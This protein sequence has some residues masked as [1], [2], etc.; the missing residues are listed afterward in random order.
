MDLCSD[1]D[2]D[3]LLDA[4]K[5]VKASRISKPQTPAASSTPHNTAS[6]GDAKKRGHAS[7]PTVKKEKKPKLEKPQHDEDEEPELFQDED[8]RWWKRH[9]DLVKIQNLMLKMLD[10][11][12]LEL[13][14]NPLDNLIDLLGG[15]EKVAEM[16]GRARHWV[17]KEDGKLH[18][19]KRTSEDVPQS[20][21]NIVE[22]G[23]FMSDEKHYAIISD[24]AS[25]GISLHADRRHASC[26][27]RRLHFTMELPWSSDKTIQ[28]LG[29]S[30]R[31]NQVTA[32][33][34]SFIFTSCAGET[35]FASSAAARL[36]SLGAILRGDR[37][38]TDAGA[39]LKDFDVDNDYGREALHRMLKECFLEANGGNYQYIPIGPLPG[40]QHPA[41]RVDGAPAD[42]RPFAQGALRVIGFAPKPDQL[43]HLRDGE[44]RSHPVEFTWEFTKT[45]TVSRFLNRLLG[46]KIEHQKI[47]FQH[48]SGLFDQVV[49]D[50]KASGTYD[51]GISEASWDIMANNTKLLESGDLYKCPTSGALAKWA[52]LEIDEGVSWD[53]AMKILQ[54]HRK[55]MRSRLAI[56]EEDLKK[57]ESEIADLDQQNP[58][59]SLGGRRNTVYLQ[60]E[61]R[62]FE[63]NN[64]R[65]SVLKNSGIW[66]RKPSSR[67]H[68]HHGSHRLVVLAIEEPKTVTD[69][70][71]LLIHRP[72][73]W[74]A[75]YMMFGHLTNRYVHVPDYASP[76]EWNN[77]RN[78]WQYYWKALAHEGIQDRLFLDGDH[79]QFQIHPRIC[80]T[81]MVF[82][83][84]LPCLS[85][86]KETLEQLRVKAA[87][88]S[89]NQN[90]VEQINYVMSHDDAKEKNKPL[91]TVVAKQDKKGNRYVGV[92]VDDLSELRDLFNQIM[93][94][95]PQ[96]M[97]VKA[98]GI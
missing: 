28:Q 98:E 24:A 64:L 65:N 42:Y 35:R 44:G 46:L 38:A 60:K 67:E 72:N 23:R 69:K 34:Y 74:R 5:P 73:E 36:Q 21:V 2:D 71:Q 20:K 13:P 68:T 48:F 39:V 59:N 1:S 14:P 57:L 3:D 95:Q 75:C 41:Y 7:A 32:P 79:L 94:G 6:G 15:A 53:S 16:T 97:D 96:D 49:S 17:R 92:E 77:A 40:T 56:A 88:V 84:I 37:N 55:E 54:N 19:V 80:T 78:E 58:N 25:T 70:H 91:I 93:N 89:K 62:K 30:H 29:R 8:G 43:R 61:K 47:L 18:Y 10:D 81:H 87:R 82:G 27:R 45:I 22:R 33:I 86:L 76:I 52:S 26:G 31:S 90:G 66:M 4:T 12:L 63:V 85:I 83:A 11:S 51:S 50:A 9:K